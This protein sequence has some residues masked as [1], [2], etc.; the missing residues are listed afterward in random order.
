MDKG[1]AQEKWRRL[2]AEAR[3]AAAMGQQQARQYAH[4]AMETPDLALLAQLEQRLG[5][6]S[7]AWAIHE[8]PLL[9][10]IPLLGPLVA[11][12]GSRLVRFLM[13]NQVSLDA[14]IASILQD[15]HQAQRLLAREQIE[16]SDDLFSRLDERLLALEARSKDLEDEVAQLREQRQG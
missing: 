7:Q 12:L 5:R 6:L 3:D 1:L 14:E 11:W 13:Q 4:A 16:R 10:R 15:L 9:T 8:K 2:R